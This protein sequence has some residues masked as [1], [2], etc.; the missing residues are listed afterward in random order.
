V[1]PL[2]AAGAP[3]DARPLIAHVVYRFA[4]GGLEN[5]VVNLINHMPAARWRHVVIALTDVDAAF[6]SRVRRSD[7]RCLGLDKPDGHGVRIF[8]QMWRLLRELRPDVVHTRNLAALEMQVPA[9]AAGVQGRVHGEH[10]RDAEDVQGTSRRN[11]ATRRLYR[12]F[13]QQTIALG[14]DIARYEHQ[15]IGVPAARLHTIYNGVDTLRFTPAEARQP[16][17]GS[18]FND[19]KLWLAGTVGR[20][21][22]V[23]AQPV[24]AEAFVAALRQQP[25]CRDRL[26]LVLVGD[27]PLRR[28][29]EDIVAAAGVSEL[30]WFAG[31]RADVPDVMRGL[32]CFVLPSLVEG[33]SNTI[34]EAMSSALPVLATRVGANLELVEEGVTGRVVPASDA[35]ALADGLLALAADP[36]GAQAMGRAGRAA[37]ERRFSLQAMVSAYEGVYERVLRLPAK[38]SE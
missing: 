32:N 14:Q 5:G 3:I 22:T 18:P 38:W 12:P 9:W 16:I 36:E 31:E 2:S 10:G 26:R 34:L 15:R 29:C 20:M 30:V 27:G 4:V 24:L 23:K 19:P 37:V 11:I 28:A 25:A 21:M 6:A 33:I 1:A 8:P 17:S 13:V 7:V 35:Q